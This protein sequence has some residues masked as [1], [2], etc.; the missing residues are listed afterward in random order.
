MSSCFCLWCCMALGLQAWLAQ[1]R[2][3]VQLRLGIQRAPRRRIP[4]EEKVCDRTQP[5]SW[6]VGF[7]AS[8]PNPQGDSAW[9]SFCFGLFYARLVCC[10]I[11]G[12]SWESSPHAV[13]SSDHGLVVQRAGNS[14]LCVSAAGIKQ[15]TNTDPPERALGMK[16]V[17]AP[18]QLLW[19]RVALH[20]QLCSAPSEHQCHSL[21]RASGHPPV[22][23]L[24]W[25]RASQG[26][27]TCMRGDSTTSLGNLLQC[28]VT[29]C[30]PGHLYLLGPLVWFL[31]MAQCCQELCVPPCRPLLPLFF[32]LLAWAVL[33]FGEGCPWKSTSFPGLLFFPE[34]DKTITAGRTRQLPFMT[35]FSPQKIRVEVVVFNLRKDL[36]CSW[37]MWK[38]GKHRSC[39]AGLVPLCFGGN[40]LLRKQ[41]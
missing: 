24:L 37:K 31:F 40:Y 35:N 33:E 12:R 2:V 5:S 14:H 36:V 25:A 7:L 16:G 41:M 4:M 21:G 30:I 11:H 20:S 29:P 22:H 23:P 28:L 19:L 27:N 39:F 9:V 3:S 34:P 18:P 17:E 38:L 6:Q 15:T 1:S 32:R 26:F 10:K 8:Y 13:E